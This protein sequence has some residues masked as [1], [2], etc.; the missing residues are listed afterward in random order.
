MF[1][2]SFMAVLSALALMAITSV[3]VSATT[4]ASLDEEGIPSEKPTG[5]YL[6]HDEGGFH[7]RTHG[8]DAEHNFMASLQTDGLF[9][10]VEGLRNEW[11]DNVKVLDEGRLLRLSFL[12]FGDR[13]GV[14]FRIRNG[15]E[16][17]VTLW[18]DGEAMDPKSVFLNATT[19][20][21][22]HP[23]TNPFTITFDT[24]PPGIAPL[25]PPQDSPEDEDGIPTERPT[26]YYFWHDEAGFHLRTHGPDAEHN[27]MASL[28]TDGQFINVEG[29]RNEWADNVKV[30]DEGRLLRLS[31][32]TFGDRDG[33]NFRIR[34]GTELRL[35]LW[36]DGEVIDTNAIFLNAPT[37]MTDHPTA[38]PFTISW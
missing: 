17:R 15:T 7:L 28:H 14:N 24:A 30:L 22:D 5:F 38:N 35:T 11:G 2:R 20:M 23:A 33:V 31:F 6:W 25:N 19:T 8:P 32:L 9:T 10:D 13:D 18:L 4:N 12:T 21:D 1:T 34:N 16:L 26:G 3:A 27:F 36:L 29:L 37:R